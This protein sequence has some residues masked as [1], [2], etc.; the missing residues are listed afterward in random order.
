MKPTCKYMK[1]FTR[2]VEHLGK[3]FWK[4]QFHG[5]VGTHFEHFYC[6][7]DNTRSCIAE[8]ELRNIGGDCR[9]KWPYI[10]L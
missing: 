3:R 7:P 5:V 9:V 6:L 8:Q 4:R 2:L 1:Q 10:G